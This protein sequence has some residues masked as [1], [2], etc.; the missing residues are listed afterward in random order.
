MVIGLWSRKIAESA[1]KHGLGRQEEDRTASSHPME[2]SH[3]ELEEALA[4]VWSGPAAK[5]GASI[6]SVLLA[7]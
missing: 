7:R 3:R 2:L 4:E 6:E 5:A 1:R